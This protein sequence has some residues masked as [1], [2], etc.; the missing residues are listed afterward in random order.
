MTT[1]IAPPP[2]P[3]AAGQP[4]VGHPVVRFTAS[5]SGALDR[6]AE[7][8]LWSMTPD[9]EREALVELH[10]QRARLEELEL[11]L[12]VQADRDGIGADSGA[13]STPAWLAHATKT[14][15]AG[16]HRDLHLGKKLDETFHATRAALAAGLID[17]EKAGIVTAAVEA[18]TGE[19]DDLPA[20]T[21]ER[22]EAHMVDQAKEFDAPTLKQL[23]K[24]LFEVVCPEAADAAEGKKLEKEE[25]KARALAHFSVRDHGDGTATGSFKLPTLHA[26]LLKK[27]LE[28]LTSP[29]RIG[30]GRLD[31]E[32][33]KKLPH[34]TLLGHGL[35]ELVENHLTDLPSVNGS[36]FTL[37]VT[38]GIDALMS[39][40][41]VATVDT[42]HRIS[43]AEARRLACKA[44]I[45][46]MV[47][48]GDS[49]PLDLGR[50]QRLF[51]RYQK[52]AINHRYH[53]AGCAADNCDRP[54]AWMEYHH[55]DP[56]HL[57]GPR[58]RRRASR[59]APR[60][61]TWPTTPRPTT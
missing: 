29:R 12:L 47:L 44:G 35:M 45:I 54:P 60:T 22:A 41:G 58:M 50:E 19:Y 26:D 5:L 11:R 48:D 27:A 61:T 17:V 16:R 28:A 7:V 18:L 10:K 9:E 31:P 38:L 6:L 56:W 23:G 33:G 32:T 25:A 36:P 52:I 40:I 13:T 4:P 57:G 49:V 46:P 43:A 15:T 1:V 8:P 21:R 34:A 39:G 24:R 55:E 2:P 20:G 30:D 59:S 14:T 53:E 42:G 51:D 37:V 3:S